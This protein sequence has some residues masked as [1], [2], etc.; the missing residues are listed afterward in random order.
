MR[1]IVFIF[2]ILFHITSYAQTKYKSR[3]RCWCD[4]GS[5]EVLVFSKK[6]AP[7]CQCSDLGFPKWKIYGKYVS[8]SKVI[9]KL[10]GEAKE[11]LDKFIKLLQ[12]Q[13][14]TPEFVKKIRSLK[15]LLL[16]NKPTE[17]QKLLQE[18][19]QIYKQLSVLERGQI[20]KLLKSLYKKEKDKNK[21]ITSSVPPNFIVSGHINY[22][23]E[24]DSY[25]VALFDPESRQII[26]RKYFKEDTFSIAG[27]VPQ[28]H[29]FI[30]LMVVGIS[31]K[32]QE[33]ITIPCVVEPEIR[34]YV[35]REKLH[36]E[37]SA[38]QKSYTEFYA[39]FWENYLKM[40]D[41]EITEE[42]SEKEAK[43]KEKQ[44]ENLEKEIFRYVRKYSSKHWDKF[45][46]Y[47]FIDAFHEA[48]SGS[49]LRK[50]CREGKKHFPENIYVKR[51]CRRL[52]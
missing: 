28:E 18:T 15:K 37:N 36:F 44:I 19:E 38:L 1:K 47:F 13:S 10:Q 39:P 3:A 14:V 30:S 49:F 35:S 46:V 11:D 5:V 9:L 34:V 41:I 45:Y 26:A 48:Y 31:K 27:Y 42:D 51:I 21:V 50:A 29:L 17:Y 52:H 32:L 43:Q 33:Q 2:L 12:E 22:W 40:S 20:Q 25:K 8:D 23:E 4:F 7:A 16:E 24:V 6:T